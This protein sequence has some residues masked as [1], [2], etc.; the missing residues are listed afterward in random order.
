MAHHKTHQ[1]NKNT[2]FKL[3]YTDWYVQNPTLY[4]STRRSL[5]PR[6]TPRH[7][8]DCDP[9]H[10]PTIYDAEP[11][12]FKQTINVR[13]HE[14]AKRT[15]MNLSTTGGQKDDTSHATGHQAAGQHDAEITVLVTSP[16]EIIKSILKPNHNPTMTCF[17]SP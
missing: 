13:F 12:I 14:F 9:Y 6:T 4:N 2:I 15:T 8:F 7:D 5:L 11:L 1:I 17:Q 10:N 3:F 16:P